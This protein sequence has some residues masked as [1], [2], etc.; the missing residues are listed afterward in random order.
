MKEE[1]L[2]DT[3]NGMGYLKKKEPEKYSEFEERINHSNQGKSISNEKRS[4]IIAG[5]LF[6][7]L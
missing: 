2:K 3:N 4:V 1:T 6:P 5:V 7:V